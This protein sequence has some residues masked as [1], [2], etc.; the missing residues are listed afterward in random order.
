MPSKQL[1]SVI[2][3]KDKFARGVSA[4]ANGCSFP[5]CSYDGSITQEKAGLPFKVSALRPIQMSRSD[6]LVDEN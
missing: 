2:A 3:A 6:V 1:T 5:D 4:L